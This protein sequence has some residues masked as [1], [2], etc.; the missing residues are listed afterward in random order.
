MYA[1]GAA[2][3]FHEAF[4]AAGSHV[5][6]YVV[7]MFGGGNMFPNQTLG[8]TCP[9]ICLPESPPSACRDVGCKNVLQGRHIFESRGFAIQIEDVGGAFSRQIVFDV[10]TGDVWV[11]RTAPIVNPGD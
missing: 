5:S 3:L 8:R 4:L 11:K 9:F 1:L 10:R 6:E 7:K 2:E